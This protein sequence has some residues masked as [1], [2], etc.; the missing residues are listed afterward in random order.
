MLNGYQ[1][2]LREQPGIYARS[3]P[4]EA[5]TGHPWG[6]VYADCWA[7]DTVGVNLHVLH[8]LGAYLQ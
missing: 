1:S 3:P 5:I 6:A 2:I 8:P 7:G 4:T